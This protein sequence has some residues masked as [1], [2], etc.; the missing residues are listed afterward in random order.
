LGEEDHGFFGSSLCSPGDVD[1]DTTRDLAVGAPGQMES[2]GS[3]YVFAERSGQVAFTLRGR[4]AGDAFGMTLSAV[5][6]WNGDE[7][8]DLAVGAPYEDSRATDSGSLRVY[9]GATHRPLRTWHGKQSHSWF[10]GAAANPG[11]LD[12]DGVADLFVSAP[13]ESRGDLPDVGAVRLFSGASGSELRVTF[14]DQAGGFFGWQL[15]AG[16]DW[17]ADGVGDWLASSPYGLGERDKVRCGWIS[18]RS[19]ADNVEIERLTGPREGGLLGT[20]VA[21]ARSLSAKDPE[22]APGPPIVELLVAG[23]PGRQESLLRPSAQERDEEDLVIPGA[24]LQLR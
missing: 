14:G 3:V 10:G 5:G 18:L 6:D 16:F 1:K 17:N 13:S 4:R 2:R 21:V 8:A 19:T 9:S 11:D 15:A 24:A 23:A 12:G 20:S 22:G 7:A